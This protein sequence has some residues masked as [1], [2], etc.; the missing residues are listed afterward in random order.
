METLVK[1]Q[2]LHKVYFR[3]SERSKGNGLGLYIV[4]KAVEKLHGTVAFTSGIGRGSVF[5]V[6]LPLETEHPII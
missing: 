6:T 5:V 2:N 3:G 4:K 1:I